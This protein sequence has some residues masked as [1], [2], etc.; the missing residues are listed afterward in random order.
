MSSSSLTINPASSNYCRSSDLAAVW[1]V[2]EKV[3]GGGE[4]S[5]LA[6][7]RSDPRQNIRTSDSSGGDRN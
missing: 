3:E 2:Q 1:L 6:M 7:W 4:F 5:D